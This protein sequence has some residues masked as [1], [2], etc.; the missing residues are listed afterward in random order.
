LDLFEITF[1]KVS[2][3]TGDIGG[4]FTENGGLH[5]WGVLVDG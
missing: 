1:E 3:I 5:A 4:D 2:E